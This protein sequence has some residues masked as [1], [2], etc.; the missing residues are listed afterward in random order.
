MIQTSWNFLLTF[1]HPTNF[2]GLHPI[3]QWNVTY[4]RWL[5]G[6]CLTSHSAIFQ[7][8][9]DGTVIQFPNF[10]L[11]LSTKGHG[12]LEVACRAHSDTGTGTSEDIFY[13][14]AIRGPSRGEGMPGLESGSSDPQSSP[15][16]LRQV[17]VPLRHRVGQMYCQTKQFFYQKIRQ[18][19]RSLLWKERLIERVNLILSLYVSRCA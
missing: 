15:L 9:S 16:P 19:S 6:C 11:L 13:L 18:F 7:I 14:L 4:C 5:V 10:Y 8:Y 12:Q 17:E 3:T 2:I 1:R